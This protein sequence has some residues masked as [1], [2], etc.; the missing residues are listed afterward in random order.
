MRVQNITGVVVY[1]SEGERIGFVAGKFSV[2][3]SISS[4]KTEY[5]IREEIL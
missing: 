1:N 5:I 4:Q 2:S 3:E